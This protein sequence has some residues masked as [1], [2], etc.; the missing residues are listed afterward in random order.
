M[1]LFVF[2]SDW[3]TDKGDSSCTSFES[4]NAS[5]TYAAY[6]RPSSQTSLATADTTGKTSPIL[7]PAKAPVI[8]TFRPVCDTIFQACVTNVW[9][10][11]V[12]DTRMCCEAS[13]SEM[14]SL[15][16]ITLRIVRAA[17]SSATSQIGRSVI[18]RRL[19]CRRIRLRCGSLSGESPLPPFEGVVVPDPFGVSCKD[20]DF[21]CIFSSTVL[22]SVLSCCWV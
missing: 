4:Y 7:R 13:A 11:P 9:S 10:L 15:I 16:R 18:T 2:R 1:P 20:L 12:S 14:Y 22:N 21:L 19:F 17:D 3:C 8:T 5:W 6:A